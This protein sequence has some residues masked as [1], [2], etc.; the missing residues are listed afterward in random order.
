MGTSR[1]KDLI[2]SGRQVGA[3][4]ALRI[5]LVDRVVPHD[6]VFAAAVAWAAELASGAVAAQG[7]AKRAIDG[8]LATDLATG[9][10]LE[11][12]LFV[13]VFRTDDAAIGVKSFLT[14]GPGK[15]EFTGR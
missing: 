8:G 12:V 6:E 13:D 3:D 2:F 4:E 11:Q 10:R 14:N 1:A 15:A 9:L 5:G 7:L